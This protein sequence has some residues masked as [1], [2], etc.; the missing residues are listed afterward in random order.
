MKVTQ[1]MKN[2]VNR[3]IIQDFLFIVSYRPIINN[4]ALFPGHT[5]LQTIFMN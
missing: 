3:Y 4:R 5:I 1:A 2:G